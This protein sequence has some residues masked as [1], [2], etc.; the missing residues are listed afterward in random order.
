MILIVILIPHFF[1]K[2]DFFMKNDLVL[3]KDEMLN[4]LGL[5]ILSNEMGIDEDKT[6]V[7]KYFD[8]LNIYSS[9]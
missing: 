6:V 1:S 8:N 4:E 7:E 5:G 3:L 2:I 9:I